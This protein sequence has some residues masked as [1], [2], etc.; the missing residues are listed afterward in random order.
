MC[1]DKTRYGDKHIAFGAFEYRL[2]VAGFSTLPSVTRRQNRA[3]ELGW[4]DT[5][6]IDPLTDGGTDDQADGTHTVIALVEF[7]RGAGDAVGHGS[8][9]VFARLTNSCLQAGTLLIRGQRC[10]EHASTVVERVVDHTAQR[11]CAVVRQQ[12]NGVG[13][14]RRSR[15]EI[16]VGE[17]GHCSRQTAVQAVDNGDDSHLTGRIQYPFERRDTFRTVTLEHGELE[18]DGRR[19]TIG[20]L[21]HAHGVQFRA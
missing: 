10:N 13:Q 5:G 20:C 9:L 21:Q 11:T 16:G 6:I 4:I 18:F 8:A 2:E 7:L 12:G 15:L 17:C 1:G 3:S 19:S 14:Q